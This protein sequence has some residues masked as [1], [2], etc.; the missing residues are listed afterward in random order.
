M[1]N[2]SEERPWDF[3]YREAGI[4]PKFPD[5]TSIA[6]HVARH[7]RVRPE[8]LALLYLD[9][10]IDYAELD[11]EVS[12]FANVLS[13]LGITRED[14]IGLQMTKRSCESWP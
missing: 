14:V 13:K 1:S 10:T 11:R 5:G 12:K 2:L 8:S 6:E 7:A 4:H 3:I 9:R